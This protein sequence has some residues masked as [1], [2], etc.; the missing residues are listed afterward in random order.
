MVS[1]IVLPSPPFRRL[2]SSSLGRSSTKPSDALPSSSPATQLQ[3]SSN[4]CH[5]LHRPVAVTTAATP[6]METQ[7]PSATDIHCFAAVDAIG[8]ANRRTMVG[9]GVSEQQFAQNP[10]SNSTF[11]PP[12]LDSDAIADTIKSFF[13]MGA[14]AVAAAAESPS[15]T[16][17]FRQN[18]PPDL[19]SKAK[20]PCPP[21][22][23]CCR[24]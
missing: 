17:Q 11:L 10:N 6:A 4:L 22:T 14:S 24:H 1:T 23:F 18:Y 16:I 8:S 20:L 19:L 12:S 9:S 21:L 5:T 7:N 2:L 15:S 3:L 13:P